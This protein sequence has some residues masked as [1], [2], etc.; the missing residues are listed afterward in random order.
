MVNMFYLNYF[1]HD[2][3]IGFSP[4]Y[5]HL[6]LELYLAES[7]CPLSICPS[8][9]PGCS[10]AAGN[11]LSFLS[12]PSFVPHTCSAGHSSDHLFITSQVPQLTWLPKWFGRGTWLGHTQLIYSES[13][14]CTPSEQLCLNIATSFLFNQFSQPVHQSLT[15]SPWCLLGNLLAACLVTYLSSLQ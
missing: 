10:W 6:R 3:Y 14:G 4:F 13:V 1:S 9:T 15:H 5:N 8:V 2:L 12:F 11:F 7:I